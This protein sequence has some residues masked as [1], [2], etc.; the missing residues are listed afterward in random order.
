M[1]SQENKNVLVFESLSDIDVVLIDDSQSD[2]LQVRVYD[3]VKES[4]TEKE[5]E[6]T[7]ERLR[8]SRPAYSIYGHRAESFFGCYI[9]IRK[10][11]N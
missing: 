5:C 9:N 1:F 6:N 7:V 8:T 11:S 2:V 10:R 4:A 3:D